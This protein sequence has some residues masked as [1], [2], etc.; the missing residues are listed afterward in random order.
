MR[1]GSCSTAASALPMRPIA[2]CCPVAMVCAR[3]LPWTTRVPEYRN[4]KSSPPG[5]PIAAGALCAGA[6]RTGTDSPVSSDSSADTFTPES[7][8]ASAG[9]RS[10]SESTSR[11]P[12]TTSRP[13]M[14]RCSPSRITSA[15]GLD[16]S[17][18]A[19]S[20]RSVLRSW[21]KLMLT[22]TRTKPS[23]ISASP[24]RRAAGRSRRRRASSRN[25]GSRTTLAAMAKRLR[26]LAEG[27]SL[28]PS[29]ARRAAASSRESPS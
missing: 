8:T 6:L 16:R 25:I 2:V 23:S 14:R 21:K 27:S 1:V 5:L 12:R 28:R 15:L 24:G 20:A 17:R 19:S 7:S 4:G 13:G 11:S 29:R 18:S 9:T 22:T 3:P 10:P 26:G